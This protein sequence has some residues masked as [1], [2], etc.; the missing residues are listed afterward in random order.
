MSRY[1]SIRCNS[2][3]SMYFPLQQVYTRRELNYTL[4]PSFLREWGK[5]RD[6][7][8]FMN[9]EMY[10][11]PVE[12]L[13]LLIVWN[14]SWYE[15]SNL[16]FLDF[17]PQW[18]RGPANFIAMSESFA[19]IFRSSSRHPAPPPWN[20]RNSK[21]LLA[22]ISLIIENFITK[23]RSKYENERYRKKNRIINLILFKNN[24]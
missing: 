19:A 20:S 6:W 5:I 17:S 7:R 8:R 18:N 3:L 16:K 22:N 1:I 23:L 14:E 4:F 2:D 9:I 10:A 13:K 15:G 11:I 21:F 12:L 24:N